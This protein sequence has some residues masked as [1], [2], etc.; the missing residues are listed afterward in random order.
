MYAHPDGDRRQLLLPSDGTIR[1]VE[2]VAMGLMRF[3][4]ARLIM[5]VPVD[6]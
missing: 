3:P 6:S 4:Q 5:L 1:T 2:I